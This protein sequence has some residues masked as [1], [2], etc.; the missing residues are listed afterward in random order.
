M[1]LLNFKSN[2]CRFIYDGKISKFNVFD[3]EKQ[4]I[5]NKTA[6]AID[7]IIKYEARK[8][9]DNDTIKCI[10]IID[11]DQFY[12]DN[13]LKFDY[14][15]LYKTVMNSLNI[16]AIYS[17]ELAL[18]INELLNKEY[19]IEK[20]KPKGGFAILVKTE[21][22]ETYLGI[23]EDDAIKFNVTAKQGPIEFVK[24][25]LKRDDITKVECSKVDDINSVLNDIG[26]YQDFGLIFYK[27][28]RFI[29]N[30]VP[31]TTLDD[32]LFEIVV[33]DN[34]LVVTVKKDF[35]KNDVE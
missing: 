20:I 6:L 2:G 7:V 14:D 4:V 11:L 15:L 1:E 31:Y 28:T 23:Y 16:D 9:I 29:N 25:I 17:N 34:H 27:S 19:F 22:D 21:D 33:F 24:N 30:F 8:T 3:R 5:E 18:N 12:E 26:I 10:N 32:I 13:L 35:E